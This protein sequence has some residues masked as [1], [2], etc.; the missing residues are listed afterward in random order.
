MEPD[1]PM[2]EV[3][4]ERRRRPRQN[5]SSP[6]W[7]SIALQR[8]SHRVRTL[9]PA[10]EAASGDDDGEPWEDAAVRVLQRHLRDRESG[11]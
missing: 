7:E 8:I 11:E 10:A 3:R 6:D 4:V 5:E 2:T 1:D 9:Q